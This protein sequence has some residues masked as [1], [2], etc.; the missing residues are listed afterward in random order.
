MAKK[1]LIIRLGTLF[2]GIGAFEHALKQLKIKHE[3]LF[4][5]DNGE[6]E[7]Y[8][9]YGNIKCLTKNL[10]KNALRT[11]CEDYIN[12][13]G[14]RREYREVEIDLLFKAV[15]N[16]SNKKDDDNVVLTYYKEGRKSP[17]KH[18]LILTQDMIAALTPNSTM[19][20][21]ERFVKSLYD[22]LGEHNYVK[23]AYFANYQIE[24]AKWHEDIR[25][26]DA[27]DYR[28]K[29]DI[30]IGG[31]PC[32]SFSNYGKKLGLEDVR[33]TLFYDYARIINECRPKIFIYENV[34]NVTKND[35]GKTWKVMFQVWQS[36][37]YHIEWSILDAKD[38][39]H[40]QLRS[41][42]FLIGFREDIY[43]KPYKFPQKQTLHKKSTDFLQSNVENVYYLG[44]KGFEWI[45]SPEKNLRRSRI[46]QDVIG[47][48]TAYQQDNWIG[49]FRVEHPQKRHYDDPRIYIGKHDFN[50][51]KGL[52]DAVGR[53]M[54]P[55][56]CLNLMGFD[57]TFNIA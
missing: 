40:P 7:L 44:K 56:E 1:E 5:C 42:L 33:G 18:K 49:D 45:T 48:Q 52:V 55:R 39:N 28:N 2:S 13:I 12:K 15:K 10:S 34:E 54:T 4:A 23:D 36:L 11:F 17:I 46:N 3:I 25:F 9:S 41:R 14:V 47:C 16:S 37:G 53:K 27:N 22:N 35:G 32:Q 38:Y 26:L 30:L 57:E 31:S 50:D 8:L 21:R 20:E 19:K 24:E 51:G 29:I 43:K 6:R